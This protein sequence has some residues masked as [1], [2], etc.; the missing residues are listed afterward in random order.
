V[1]TPYTAPPANRCSIIP[2]LSPPAKLYC[3]HS[4]ALC[5]VESLQSIHQPLQRNHSAITREYAAPGKTRPGNPDLPLCLP[6]HSMG[7]I[8]S[9]R[10]CRNQAVGWTAGQ[11]TTAAPSVSLSS[12]MASA[13]GG[14]VG[15]GA[16]VHVRCSRTASIIEEGGLDSLGTLGKLTRVNQNQN[17]NQNFIGTLQ[18][19]VY[20]GHCYNFTDA[21]IL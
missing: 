10:Q 18:S 13:T 1:R 7:R 4:S 15:G 12:A 11:W 9:F 8:C 2:T 21:T 3:A 5:G 14:A 16:S 19:I 20:P 6:I 17:Q